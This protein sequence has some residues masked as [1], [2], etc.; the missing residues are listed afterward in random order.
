MTAAVLLLL[1]V[2]GCIGVALSPLPSSEIVNPESNRAHAMRRAE[3]R[4][5]V[6]IGVFAMVSFISL[7]AWSVGASWSV[8]PLVMLA[9][10]IVLAIHP[11]IFVKRLLVPL[12]LTRA[13]WTLS[14]LGGQPWVRDPEGGAVLAGALAALHSRTREPGGDLFPAG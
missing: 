12:G 5:G 11:W 10:A 6:T 1:C 9:A 3:A 14:R 8:W 13:A 4:L 2:L 7:F